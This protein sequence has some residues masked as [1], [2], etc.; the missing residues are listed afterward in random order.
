M[1]WEN[2]KQQLKT[3]PKKTL[4]FVAGLAIVLIILWIMVLFQ[5]DTSSQTNYADLE[6]IEQYGVQVNEK[7]AEGSERQAQ[8]EAVAIPFRS[9]ISVLLVIGLGVYSY[10]SYRKQYK[11]RKGIKRENIFSLHEKLEILPGQSLA[12]VEV[13]K[14]FWVVSCGNG[15]INILKS[16]DKEDWSNPEMP[17]M[18]VE[19]EKEERNFGYL[20]DSFR[21]TQAAPIN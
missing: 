9:V 12:L 6:N 4:R 8:P 13:N 16:I 5:T 17:D 18:P 2:F 14:E 19:K 15:D 10:M 11:S 20:F 21:K 1:D 3:E 7:I